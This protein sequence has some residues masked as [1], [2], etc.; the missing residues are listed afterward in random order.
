MVFAGKEKIDHLELEGDTLFLQ[1][2]NIE[3]RLA[4]ALKTKGFGYSQ[5]IRFLKFERTIRRKA[6]PR[7]VLVNKNLK[8]K[9]HI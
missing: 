9:F 4:K 1:F 6:L 3:L 2:R 7:Q 8:I 5:P